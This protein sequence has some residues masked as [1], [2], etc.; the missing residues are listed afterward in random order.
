MR[1]G[2]AGPAAQWAIE[3]QI[4]VGQYFGAEDFVP[5]T[6]AHIMA[7]TN[8]SNV[9]H[10]SRPIGAD[11]AFRPSPTRAAPTLR[12]HTGSSSSPGCSTSSAARLQR[13]RRSAC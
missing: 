12:P 4:K 9:W 5:V 11:C 8:G 10:A 7:D 6:Q 3:H 13:S 2:E 1:A